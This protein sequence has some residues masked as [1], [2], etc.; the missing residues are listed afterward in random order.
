MSRWAALK[1]RFPALAA[2]L[3]AWALARIL[4]LVAALGAEFV[5]YNGHSWTSALLG[6]Q[7]GLMAWDADWY[8]RIARDGYDALPVEGIRYFPLYPIAARLLS[9]VLAG[10]TKA[11]LLILA[12][13]FAIV[14][15]VL[16]YRLC[17]HEKNEPALARRST[18]LVALAPPSFVLAMGYTEALAMTF[19][20]SA[21]LAM[22]KNRW[23]VAAGA[24]LLAG[25]VRPTGLLLL[26][27]LLV[28]AMRDLRPVTAPKLLSRAVALASPLVG[29]GIYLAWSAKSYGDAFL[30]LSV[31]QRSNARGDL[32]NPLVTFWD[33]ARQLF[34]DARVDQG[35]HL[36]WVAL[37]VYLIVLA[38]RH[39]PASYGTFATVSLFQAVS[40]SNLNSLERYCY[41]AFPVI[42]AVAYAC[43]S[44]RRERLL[45]IC[46]GLAMTAYAA[47]A[48]VSGYVP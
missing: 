16:V 1:E 43:R 35:L 36:I 46:S 11:A 29:T 26:A 22:R 6:H 33:A 25:L 12:N 18:W 42:L 38:F 5:F 32:Q 47:A 13:G 48:F 15:G 9:A 41:G 39:W 7:R 19:A 2:T 45:L 17:M 30:P 34:T 21:F 8:L 44:K 23:L 27:P 4:V 14:L 20:L 10:A 3:P 28:E 37:F 24:G 40:T 31:Q